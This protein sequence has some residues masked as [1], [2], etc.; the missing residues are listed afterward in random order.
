MWGGEEKGRVSK[1]EILVLA[2]TVIP[3]ISEL[4]YN[5]NVFLCHLTVL[6]VCFF[7]VS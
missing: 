5:K 2:A 3:G 4:K 7:S 6:Y 1:L